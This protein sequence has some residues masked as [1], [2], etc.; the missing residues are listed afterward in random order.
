MENAEDHLVLSVVTTLSSPADAQALARK[1]LDARLAACVQVEPGITSHYRWK[2]AVC[3]DTEVRLT[4]KT[5]ARHAGA[6]Q[7][8]FAT[9]HP[10]EVPQFLSTPMTASP[11]YGNWVRD[12]VA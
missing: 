12:E 5:L 4:I 2:G 1:I 11:A 7:A 10:Y 3:E 8:L 9:E 6:L